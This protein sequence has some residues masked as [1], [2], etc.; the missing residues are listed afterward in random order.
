LAQLLPLRHPALQLRAPFPQF[1]RN[2]LSFLGADEGLE[3]GF[4]LGDG[5]F[6]AVDFGLELVNAVFHLL[7][8]D[9]IQAP[10]RGILGLC[11]LSIGI[12]IRRLRMGW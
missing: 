11:R 5:I 12:A 4:A 10:P 3:A 1:L 9:G 8:F 7:A 2:P 6:Q